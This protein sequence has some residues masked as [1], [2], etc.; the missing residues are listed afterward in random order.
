MRSPR[1]AE[2]RVYARDGREFDVSIKP[3][4]AWSE[5]AGNV[6]ALEPER[7]EATAEDGKLIRAIVVSDLVAKEQKAEQSQAATQQ[8][9]MSADPETQRLI[10]FA[11]LVATAHDR[12][13]EAQTRT[14]EVAFTKMQEICDA[15][16]SQANAAQSSAN[17]LSV[18]IRNLMIQQ[19]Q[20]AAD[21]NR[22]T[23]Q[24]SQ[25]EQLAS[26]FLSGQQLAAAENKPNGKGAHQ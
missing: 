10:V 26:N 24:P 6:A 17:D 16:A 11:Q 5:T 2:L 1:P 14:L 12:A 22:E 19:A 15:L 9:M 13:T 7:I 8:A 25:L 23:A 3:G 20:E 18:A 21:E 4:A